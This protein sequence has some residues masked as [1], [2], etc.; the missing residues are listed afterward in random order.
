MAQRVTGVLKDGLL[1]QL[2]EIERQIRQSSGYPFDPTMLKDY[3]QKGIEGRFAKT[4][5]SL[6]MVLGTVAVPAVK[7]FLTQ[8]NFVVDTSEDAPVKISYV[9]DNFLEWFGSKTETNVSGGVLRY[10]KLLRS[11]LDKPIRDEIGKVYEETALA[12]IFALMKLQPHGQ[13][14]VLFTDGCANIFYASDITGAVRAV[15]VY[16]RGGG[17]YVYACSASGPFE[18][19]EG[20]RVFSRNS[21]AT[22][23]V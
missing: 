7:K 8:R 12:H 4:T 21:S 23:T 15:F 1:S 13:G 10:A 5:S 19:H 18:W 22:V 6:L 20:G 14:G 11:S 9:S 17:W 16:W 2:F 3:L